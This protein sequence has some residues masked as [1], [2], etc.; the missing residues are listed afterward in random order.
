VI[1]MAGLGAAAIV[2]ASARGTLTV[3]G[4]ALAKIGTP[5]GGGTIE[6]VSVV[7][8]PH[9][10][11]VPITV[12]GHQVWPAR[13][14]RAGHS[15]TVDVTIRRPGWLSWLTGKREHLRLTLRTPTTRVAS[16]YVTLSGAAPLQVHFVQPAAVVAYGRPGHLHRQPLGSASTAATVPHS[17]P[18][19]SIWVSAVPRTW[20]TAPPVLVSWFPA[21]SR[22]SAVA[23]PAPGTTIS[24]GTPIMLTFSKP[25]DQAL[26]KSRPPVLPITQGVW[27]QLNS[28][29]IV[30]RPEGYG[31]GLGAHVTVALPAGVSLAAGTAS[32]SG[33]VGAWQVPGGST[34]RL[35]QLLS[36]LG[37]LPFHFNYAGG[38]GVA[39]TPAAQEAAAASPPSGTFDWAYPNVPS[40]LRGMWQPGTSGEMTKG[41][42][43][44]FENDHGLGVDGTAGPVVWKSLIGAVLDGKKSSF[45]YTFVDVHK[46]ASP[47]SLSLW[48]NGKTVVTAAVN[49][50][51]PAAPT[52]SGTFAV[53]EHLRVTTMSG[54][55]PDG[56]HYND[57][58]IQFV[59]Y[60]NG[61]DALHAFTRAQYGFPQSLGCVEMGLASAGQ[62]W[63]YTPIG[64]LVHVD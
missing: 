11:P 8:G 37:Y 27:H 1:V 18:A 46:Q 25:V 31:Y 47:Q 21:G 55:N 26:G 39:L 48:H 57:P 63:P 28:H 61:G 45:G 38:K 60:F 64:T 35:Q 2:L 3:D 40:A 7:S 15:V 12:R 30:F 6:S 22:A 54:T 42:I 58:G 41:A 24:P 13:A 51:I 43:M 14:I 34:L 53:Y 16:Q 36:M 44:A 29:T 49:T 50:G 10:Q 56:S 5:L 17:G 4:S 52:Q 9:S 19:G 32:K 23:S 59:S 20:E 33:T 62:V